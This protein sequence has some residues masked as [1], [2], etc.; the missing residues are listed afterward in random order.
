MPTP[1]KSPSA[2]LRS[3]GADDTYLDAKTKASAK[4]AEMRWPLFRALA[5]AQSAPTPRLNDA[6][7]S[8]W[9]HQATAPAPGRKPVLSR[10][11]LG[12]KLA[13]SLEK[14]AAPSAAR[15][16]SKPRAAPEAQP[17]AMALP[18]MKPPAAVRAKSK[19][20]AATSPE[21]VASSTAPRPAFF[22]NAA[23]TPKETPA[24]AA[25]FGLGKA[26]APSAPAAPKG[27]SVF[28]SLADAAVTAPAPPAAE[29]TG[30][31]PDDALS[32]V[33]S[34]VEGRQPPTK[35]AGASARSAVMRR[36][37]KR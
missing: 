30:A 25:L 23:T 32:T 9:E 3:L 19:S 12:S 36:I 17:P 5:P 11:G 31:A 33:F 27:N 24:A 10:P 18:A 35:K 7:K 22:A 6:E 29:R 21:A 26:S 20:A 1:P 37:G 28:A 15:A 14:L 13:A 8:A 4:E 2:L 34:R 16:R